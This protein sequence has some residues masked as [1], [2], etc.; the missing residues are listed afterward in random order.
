MKASQK[1]HHR[2]IIISNSTKIIFGCSISNTDLA[3]FL[4]RQIVKEKLAS[5]DV[6]VEVVNFILGAGSERSTLA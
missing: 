2:I 4:V 5:K 6:E 1:D 3:T